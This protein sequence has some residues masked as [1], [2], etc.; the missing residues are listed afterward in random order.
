MFIETIVLINLAC[1][2]KDICKKT[3]ITCMEQPQIVSLSVELPYSAVNRT[4][5]GENE[6]FVECYK[7]TILKKE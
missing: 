5:K 7:S 3:F 6:L 1:Q 4:Y 2:E